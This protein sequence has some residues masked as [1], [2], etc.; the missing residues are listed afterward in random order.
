MLQIGIHD[1]GRGPPD[2]IDAAVMAI[3]LPKFRLNDSARM[4]GFGGMGSAQKAERIV[5]LNRRQQKGFRKRP[6]Q[7]SRTGTSRFSKACIFRDSCRPARH[8]N[9][10]LP[11]IHRPASDFVMR[12]GLIS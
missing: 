8:G 10:Q 12:G 4:R 1:D 7:S 9:L 3:S 2:M 6:R 11:R 5:G